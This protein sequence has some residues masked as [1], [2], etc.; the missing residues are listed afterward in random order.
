M[1]PH[2][3]PTPHKGVITIALTPL[4]EAIQNTVVQEILLNKPFGEGLGRRGIRGA[5]QNWPTHLRVHAATFAWKN[6]FPATS[7]YFVQPWNAHHF[8][9]EY[10]K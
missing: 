3:T 8:I 6:L 2:I 7:F 5:Q 9:L 4:V 10:F 1:G